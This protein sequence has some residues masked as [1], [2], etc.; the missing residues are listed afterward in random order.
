MARPSAFAQKYGNWL[1]KAAAC[2]PYAAQRN[3]GDRSASTPIP[4]LRCAVSGL[5]TVVV[6]ESGLGK[7]SFGL[8]N[9]WRLPKHPPIPWLQLPI[10]IKPLVQQR[11]AEHAMQ[12]PLHRKSLLRLAGAQSGEHRAYRNGIVDGLILER[13]R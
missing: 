11:R 4:G 10:H 12:Q 7:V 5:H 13:F 2:S 1:I 6:A 8:R 3:T 9:E